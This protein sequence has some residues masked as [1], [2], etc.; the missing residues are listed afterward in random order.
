MGKQHRRQIG[1]P[2]GRIKKLSNIGRYNFQNSI[3]LN[4]SPNN[5]AS[6]PTSIYQQKLNKWETPASPLNVISS[7][8]S[9][10][11]QQ[12]TNR[13]YQRN[14]S[15]SNKS[16]SNNSSS[17]KSSSNKKTTQKRVS[18]RELNSITG[19]LFPGTLGG[20]GTEEKNFS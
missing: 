12:Q 1:R 13:F 4:A 10:Y 2:K 9:P 14:K 20:V 7:Y 17:N 18:N 5:T 19:N 16:S 8:K 6:P 11:T 15:L 3:D